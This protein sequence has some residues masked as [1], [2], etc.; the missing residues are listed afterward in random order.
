MTRERCS[1]PF[2]GTRPSRPT[3]ATRKIRSS[4]TRLERA[5]AMLRVGN[6]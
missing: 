2:R 6:L 4:E 1:V 3:L 5:Y